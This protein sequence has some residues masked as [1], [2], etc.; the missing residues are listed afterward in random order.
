MADDLQAQVFF[1]SN[2]FVINNL[3]H[4]GS[5]DNFLSLMP[6]WF[7]GNIELTPERL[8]YNSIQC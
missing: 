6:L 5:P 1:A 7:A 8:L 3:P 4:S 2:A